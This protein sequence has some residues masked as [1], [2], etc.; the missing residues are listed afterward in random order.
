MDLMNHF[1]IIQL[2]EEF[3]GQFTCLRANTEKH[4]TLSVPIQKKVTKIDKNGDILQI[5]IYL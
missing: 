4:I 3:E 1:I 2:E 5:T